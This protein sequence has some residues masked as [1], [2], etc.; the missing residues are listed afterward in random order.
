MTFHF[1]L[2]LPI[3]TYS[4]LIISVSPSKKDALPSSI[5][6]PSPSKAGSSSSAVPLIGH[7]KL[8]AK[9]SLNSD[10]I[11]ML[12]AVLCDS[13]T[14]VIVAVRVIDARRFNLTWEEEALMG[15]TGRPSYDQEPGVGSLV[16][17]AWTA[18]RYE[19]G[20]EGRVNL[21]CNLNWVAVLNDRKDA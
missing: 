7:G 1:N 16:L 19:G 6:M 9:A 20:A 3:L 13:C 14:D 10:D 4:H 21:G 17:V 12:F 8:A 11:G 5:F 2:I 18:S 15:L